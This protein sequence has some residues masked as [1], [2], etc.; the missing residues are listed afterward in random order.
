MKRLICAAVAAFVVAAAVLAPAAAWAA[1]DRKVVFAFDRKFMPFSYVRNQVPT[2]FEVE[3]FTAVLEGSGLGIEYKPMR[4]WERAQAELSGG[5]IQ[6]AA[7]MTK[8]PLRE[9]VFIFPET[10]TMTLDLKF[11]ANQTSNYT[12][13]G[14]LRGQTIAAIRDS[15]YQRLLQEFGGVKIKLY[16]DGEQALKAVLSGDA[17]AYFGTDKIARDIIARKN[18]KNLVVIGSTVRS[19]PVY[20]ALYKGETGLRDLMDRGLKRL[21]VNGEYDRIYRK[22]FV[23]EMTTSDMGRLVAEAKKVLPMAYAP[24]SGKPEAAAVL[25]RSGAVFVGANIENAAPGAGIGALEVA[26]TKAVSAGQLQIYAA[27]KISRTGLVLPPSAAE[28]QLLWE[29]GRS[30]L[31]LLEPNRGEYEAWSLPKLLPFPDRMPG[32]PG[33]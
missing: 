11:F 28:R 3:L 16:E 31:V 13:V 32:M 25:T 15:L 19:V 1:N 7:G 14:Q 12:H 6:V 23:P 2:G 21:M 30:V 10:P 9:K 27:V 17:A 8:T 4:D 20:Y 22:W 29:Y 24:H 18:M 33:S 26:L 5:L